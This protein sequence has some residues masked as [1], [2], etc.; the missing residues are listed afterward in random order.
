MDIA[1]SLGKN[2]CGG[3]SE[4]TKGFGMYS[5][6]IRVVR[7]TQKNGKTILTLYMGEKINNYLLSTNRSNVF[8]VL[9]FM[10]KSA[11]LMPEAVELLDDAQNIMKWTC[12]LCDG[13]AC[14]RCGGCDVKGIGSR[15]AALLAKLEGG[16]DDD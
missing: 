14:G 11:N 8:P 7:Y 15:I 13:E 16:A 9:E 2:R 10:A 12:E 6:P 1:D 3:M 5:L 4:L